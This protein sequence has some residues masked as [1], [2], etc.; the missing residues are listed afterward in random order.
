MFH[1]RTFPNLTEIPVHRLKGEVKEE[2]CSFIHDCTF[3]HLDEFLMKNLDAH[4]WSNRAPLTLN[5]GA[6]HFALY[7]E[8]LELFARFLHNLALRLGQGDIF[9]VTPSE[10]LDWM[11]NPVSANE[12]KRKK[13]GKLSRRGVCELRHVCENM[14]SP[15]FPERL[16]AGEKMTFA[17]CVEKCPSNHPYLHNSNG[18]DYW[19]NE[20]KRNVS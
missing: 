13:R 12:Y 14:T 20:Q 5:F 18:N 11:E 16:L 1:S 8:H 7:P 10:V 17:S 19:L 4:Y 9:F 3:K 15:W 6:Q 2:T